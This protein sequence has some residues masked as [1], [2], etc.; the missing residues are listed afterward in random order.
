MTQVLE[1]LECVEVDGRQVYR[2]RRCERVLGSASESYKLG[3][4][5]FELPAADGVPAELAPTEDRYVLRHHC[6]P[7]CAV[8]F[9]VEMVI[10]GAEPLAS[11]ELGRAG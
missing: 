5:S 6:C 3:A 7:G 1:A 9:E 4:M 10:A 8:L 2:C 11:V